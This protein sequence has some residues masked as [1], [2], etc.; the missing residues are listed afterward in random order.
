MKVRKKNEK[1]AVHI[2]RTELLQP[3]NPVGVNLI[4]AGGTGG[5][6]LTALA[7]MNHA[8]TALG[9]AGIFVRVFD[10][11]IVDVA[12]LGRQLFTTA[13]VGLS[14]SVALINRI[15]RFFGTNW[16]AETMRY[17]K[18]SQ[19]NKDIAS[20]VITISCVD[21]AQARYDIAEVLKYL[22]KNYSGRNHV[23]YWMDFGNSRTSGQVILSTIGKIS[24][25]ISELYRPVDHLPLVTDEFKEL[26]YSSE[27]E[28]N[29]PS[30]SLA[31]AL[32]KQDLFINSALANLG[33]SLL[34]QLFRE[35]ILFNR[36]FFLNLKDFRTQPLKVA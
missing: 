12:N 27:Q 11:D 2:V 28:D 20:A 21:T 9:H 14:K 15:N 17:D 29:T 22:S 18:Q 10:D 16:K 34:W 30:C 3:Y 36:G 5:Q 32:T 7:R 6:V 26:L 24:Q 33:A 35:G 4:G 25:P 13:E 19:N 31:E 23:Q 1:P 8:L